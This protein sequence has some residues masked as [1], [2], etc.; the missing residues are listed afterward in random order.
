[1]KLLKVGIIGCGTIGS[2]IARA[3][4]GGWGFRGRAELVALCD[5]DE[6][7]ALKLANSL[8]SKPRVLGLDALIKKSHLV[9]EAASKD[10]SGHIARKVIIDGR[11]IMV[12]SVGGLVGKRNTLFKLA[13]RLN[14]H[15]YI[16]SGALCGLDAVKSAS[17]GEITEASLT[18]RKPPRALEGA[19][20]LKKK[21]I[22]LKK[23][24][25]QTLIFEGNV[26]DA[27]EGFPRNINVSAALGLAGI[28]AERTRVRIITS[29]KYK[30]NSHEIQ[31]KGS[32]GKLT[33]RTENVPSPKN[34]KTSYLAVL[35]AIATL[36]GII[37]YVKLGT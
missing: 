36:K 19:P 26:F 7:K 10:V 31:L 18:T 15:V 20:Y 16:P 32:F 29:P 3:L 27:I 9:I 13:Q 21:R 12:M 22:D 17:L 8:Y 24:K 37:S 28:G 4:D 2:Q 23:I 6:E 33:A 11:D 25:K 35:S 1:M 34:P 14:R 5:I 30:G